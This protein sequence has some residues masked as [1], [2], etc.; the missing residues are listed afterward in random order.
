MNPSGG[1]RWHWR[2]WRSAALW[3]PT[4]AQ[5]ADWLA[6]LQPR[7]KRLLLLG[8]SAGWMLP[9]EWLLRFERIDAM[10]MDPFAGWLFGLRHGPALKAAGVSWHYQTGDALAALP[11]L[12]TVHP[13]ACVLLD[14]LLGQLRFHAPPW[15]DPTAYTS[16]QLAE[17]K[18][19]LQ[20]REWGSVHDL[21]SGPAAGLSPEQNFP[22]AR[23]SLAVPAAERPPDVAWLA[24]AQ[25]Q[26]EWLD[27]L[28]DQVFAAD[29]PVQDMAWAF[30]PDYWH[31]L[32]AGWVQPGMNIAPEKMRSSIKPSFRLYS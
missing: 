18:R 10:D 11:R 3:S 24:A 13:R 6:S 5:I 1:L 12:L 17:V 28:T 32:Q 4:S 30:S 26:G 20:G 31:W 23:S 27:H 15:Q 9:T 14:N 2:A 25:P 7:S 8:P 21:L 16:C 29:T 19:L 22:P